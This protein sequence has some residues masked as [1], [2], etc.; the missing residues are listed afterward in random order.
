M[1]SAAKLIILLLV[2]AGCS[3]TQ[4]TAVSGTKLIGGSTVTD[5]KLDSF[6][7]ISTCSAVLVSPKAI[8][9]AAHCIHDFSRSGQIHSRYRA[10]QEIVIG[11]GPR[12]GGRLRVRIESSHVHPSWEKAC[13][14]SNPCDPNRAGAG[15]DPSV[16]DLAIIKLVTP[17]TS[18]PS[19]IL[20]LEPVNPNDSVTVA[21]YGCEG[22]INTG[23]SGNRKAMTTKTVDGK[24][25]L[26]HAGSERASAIAE[27]LTANFVTPGQPDGGPSLCPGDSGGP[28]YRANTNKLVGINAD[29]TFTGAY[30]RT[31]AIAKTN[32]H[33]R[34]DAP[35]VKS[36]LAGL[37]EIDSNPVDQDIFLALGESDRTNLYAAGSLAAANA[38]VCQGHSLKCEESAYTLTLL[39]TRDDRKFFHTSSAGDLRDGPLT[40]VARDSQGK[41]IHRKY[42]EIVRN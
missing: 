36:W 18:I 11:N 31:G 27:T 24:V 23:S 35:K 22:G 29:Y 37:L 28:V 38:V 1:K 12:G 2:V 5:S 10:G 32:I 42:F 21:G 26:A 25:A 3:P 33:A 14:A 39:Q 7:S 15:N 34:F 41:I 8:M 16:S 40:I 19:A 30:E 13:T 4:S 9:T 6:L 17:V 20:D